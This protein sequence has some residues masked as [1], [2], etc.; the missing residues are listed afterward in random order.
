MEA[1][2]LD[3]STANRRRPW[4]LAG[5]AAL[6]LIVG[7]MAV[8]AVSFLAQD[9]DLP[10]GPIRMAASLPADTVAY[11]E[12]DLEPDGAQGEALAALG[13]R[14]GDPDA[15]PGI[16]ALLD[17]LIAGFTEGGYDYERDVAAWFDGHAAFAVL[18]WG[19][20]GLGGMLTPLPGDPVA[21]GA[22]VL[23]GVDD[24]E[25]ATELTDRL[26]A[27]AR[28]AGFG[29]VS[30]E[31]DG[32]TVWRADAGPGQPGVAFAVGDE[33]LVLGV[34]DVDIETVIDLQA[35]GGETLALG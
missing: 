19:S 9:Q 5:V 14:F 35:A 1:D 13:A 25:A 18:D 21:P 8:V 33:L 10:A 24:R 27:D 26:R 30:R 12:L 22:V 29:F 16:A 28:A 15:A 11:L 3:R 7:A 31:I 20:V 6:L 17:P 23:L 34:S 32:W 2:A 4:L